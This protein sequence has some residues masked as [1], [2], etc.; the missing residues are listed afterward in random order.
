MFNVS[1]DGKTIQVPEGTTVLRAAEQAGI[2]IP[3]L[4]DHP[5]LVPFGGCRLCVVEV[6]GMRTM[7]PAC[8]LPVSNNMVV[9]TD[10]EKVLAARKFV[11]TLI[12]SDRNH[13]CP[14]CQVSGGDCDLQNAALKMGMTH[15]EYQPN[16]KPYPVDASHPYLVIDHN[17]CILCRR[18]VRVCGELVGNFTLGVEERGASS[19]LMCDV[20]VPFGQ[21]SCISCGT[22][23]QVCPTGAI[24]DRRSAYQ[25]L[26]KTDNR[27]ASICLGCSVGCG[28]DVLTRDNRLVR[29]LGRWDAPVNEGVLCKQG[30]FVPLEEDRKRIT[31]PMLRKDGRLEPVSW[32]E[33]VNA[34][35]THLKPLAGQSSHGVAAVVS[36]R[37][38]IESLAAFKK[39]FKSGLGADVVTS[40]EEGA[41]TKASSQLANE[42][43][44]FETDLQN[45]QSADCVVIVGANLANDAQVMGFMVKRI[46]P[47]NKALVLV[48]A[49]ENAFASLARV[50]LKPVVGTEKFVVQGLAAAVVK[51]GLAKTGSNGMDVEVEIQN[52]VQKTGLSA[53]D[54]SQAA[55]IIGNA[56]NPVFI[57]GKDLDYSALKAA[58]SLANLVGAGK[59]LIGARSGAN[60]LATA[61]FGLDQPFHRNGH[62][63]VYVAL[64]DDTPAQHLIQKIEGVPFLAVQASYTS[65]LTAM[66]DVILPVEM[67]AETS[68]HYLNI[69][70]HMQEA[71][72]AISMSGEIRSNQEA[73]EAVAGAL[74]VTTAFDWLA[75]LE[76]R[77]SPVAFAAA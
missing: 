76:E 24:I 18:C 12:F 23:S 38:S 20:G 34:V 39:L 5:N 45:L 27:T 69:D 7:Q 31:T 15:W 28:I 60:S 43:G 25:G 61:Q 21:S 2:S 66:A 65:R 17:R 16:W 50:S 63:A 74:G 1:I 26:E 14:Y 70:G 30:R 35:S 75:E 22:C 13:F 10:T 54:L 55:A 44:P 37:L 9:R 53:N 36:P 67:W 19:M 47:A 29:V 73:L 48:D 64:G 77:K 52:A 32:A 4:C 40:L 57:Y 59:K 46:L 62:Q 8:S 11:L 58:A 6:E 68:G 3:V 49:A 42:I 51:M 71:V 56:N 41:T 72:S 33:A